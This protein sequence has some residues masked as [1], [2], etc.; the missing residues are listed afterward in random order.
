M[1]RVKKRVV[2]LC[3]LDLNWGEGGRQ[4]GRTNK[5]SIQ[6]ALIFTKD[7]LS[8]TAWLVKSGTTMMANSNND[9]VY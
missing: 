6:R 8:K 9:L 1:L 5:E 2:K 7:I 4:S 3:S